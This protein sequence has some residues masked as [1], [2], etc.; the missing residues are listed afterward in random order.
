VV[1]IASSEVEIRLCASI[2]FLALGSGYLTA[3]PILTKGGP[4]PRI[5]DLA[6]QLVDTLSTRAN[7]VGVS[8]RGIAAS[9]GFESEVTRVHCLIWGWWV[10]FGTRSNVAP[11]HAQVAGK[12]V[13]LQEVMR[14][15]NMASTPSSTMLG[16]T[17]TSHPTRYAGANVAFDTQ[18]AS[19]GMRR[20]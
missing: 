12:C 3:L 6:N 20:S 7:S 18:S 9:L 4:S 5:L 19:F 15:T 11:L 17:A 8:S 1:G 10:G 2:H 13:T 16:T 14:E